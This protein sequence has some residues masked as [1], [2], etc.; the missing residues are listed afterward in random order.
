[1][2]VSRGYAYYSLKNTDKPEALRILRNHADLLIYGC[3]P[4]SKRI[5]KLV[6]LIGVRGSVVALGWY[7]QLRSYVTH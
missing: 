3:S 5:Q 7:W 1:M 4:K 2:W 6:K